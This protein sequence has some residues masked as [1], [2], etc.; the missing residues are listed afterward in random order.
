M[1]VYKVWFKKPTQQV[2]SAGRTSSKTVKC[3]LCCYSTFTVQDNHCKHL[4]RW[5]KKNQEGYKKIKFPLGGSKQYI[6]FNL[7]TWPPAPLHTWPPMT[8]D[9]V[10]AKLQLWPAARASAIKQPSICFSLWAFNK[11]TKVLKT[12]FW[13]RKTGRIISQ[14]AGWVLQIINNFSCQMMY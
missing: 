8:I 1:T 11:T 12:R 13:H 6:Q 4:G 2:R 7:H 9:T 14:L 5:S 3:I 10:A